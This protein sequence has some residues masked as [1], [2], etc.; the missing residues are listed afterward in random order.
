MAHPPTGALGKFLM[1][2][3]GWIKGT[4]W[5]NL[6]NNRFLPLVLGFGFGGQSRRLLRFV[7]VEDGAA[8]AIANIGALAIELGW[9]MQSKEVSQKSLVA[10]LFGVKGDLDGFGMAG[11]V[12]ADLFVGG[13]LG[14][15]AG[16]ASCGFS[17]TGDLV[18]IVLNSP[19]AAGRKNCLFHVSQYSLKRNQ[20]YCVGLEFSAR[21][22]MD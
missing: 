14:V 12:G 10:D 16:I 5:R 19:K 21:D 6:R 20:P 8:I 2:V 3:F 11:G 7:L 9:V 22:R 13:V 1:I 4:S 15:S 18:K 17:N